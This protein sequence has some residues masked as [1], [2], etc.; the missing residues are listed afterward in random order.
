VLL[1]MKLVVRGPGLVGHLE[2]CR[3]VGREDCSPIS[4]FTLKYCTFSSSI[5][6]WLEVRV[7]MYKS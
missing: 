4:F 7:V 2:F 3:H 5:F 6:P 1:C